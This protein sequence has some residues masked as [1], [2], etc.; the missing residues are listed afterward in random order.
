MGPEFNQLS[1]EDGTALAFMA[2]GGHGC[3]SVTANVAPKLCAEF[4]AACLAGDFAL[5]LQ[6]QDRLTPLHKAL[7]L[8]PSPAPTKYAL[9]RLGKMR[10]DVRSPIVTVT[11]ETRA[12][13]DEAMRHAGLLN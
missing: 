1:G 11:S 4:Q 10:E 7:F 12:E 13:V 3:I 5:A 8:E 6:Y 9:S 2:H